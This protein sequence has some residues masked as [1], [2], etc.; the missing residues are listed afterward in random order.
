MSSPTDEKPVAESVES[1]RRVTKPETK[2]DTDWVKIAKGK[3]YSLIVAGLCHG[4][5][6]ESAHDLPASSRI[7]ALAD[8]LLKGIED[9][10]YF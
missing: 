5:I 10:K 3:T 9:R 7:L 1:G 8:E 6:V 4:S 2:K